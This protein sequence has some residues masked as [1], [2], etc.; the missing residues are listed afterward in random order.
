MADPDHDPVASLRTLVGGFRLTQAIHVAAVLGIPDLLSDRS[1]P[2]ADLARESGADEQA[3][4]RLLRALAAADVFVEGP[5]DTF[6]NTEMGHALESAHPSRT[7]DLAANH[8]R[9]YVW[10]TWGHLLTSIQ[11]GENAFSHLHG[12]SV[13]DYRSDHPADGEAF[14]R[15]MTAMTIPLVEAVAGAYD[16]TAAK[17]IA[18]VG[19]GQGALLA[20]V[21]GVAPAS[22][23]VLF[24]QAHVVEEA[25]SYLHA[26]GVLDRVTITGG[27]FFESVPTGA[28]VYLLKSVLHD[29]DDEDCLRI[30]RRCRTAMQPGTILLIVERILAGPNQGLDT[31][32][33][34]LNMLVMPGGRERSAAEYE[35][36]LDAT[37][38]TL[39]RVHA[40]ST[41]FSVI[42]S[43][44]V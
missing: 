2:T 41:T 35:A 34:D 26:A 6:A 19:G 21:L 15:A 37:D 18:D 1:R 16:F 40:T 8:G 10:N 32:L 36:L 29:W 13:W 11:T 24:D 14:D 33:S 25:S 31:K 42:E 7:R 17:V 28:D 12:R 30:L 20:A 3:L 43:V 23:G 27:S 22:R 38:L 39:A 4:R 5:D 9:G 44:A